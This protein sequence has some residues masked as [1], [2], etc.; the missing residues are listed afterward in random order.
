VYQILCQFSNI[1]YITVVD[2]DLKYVIS[3][4]RL[5]FIK[6]KIVLSTVK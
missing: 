6:E 5:Y 4:N 1:S 2:R 3:N